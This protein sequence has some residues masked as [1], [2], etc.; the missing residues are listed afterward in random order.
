MKLLST[1]LACF[2]LLA[3]QLSARP[4]SHFKLTTG[5]MTED[6]YARWLEELHDLH[7]DGS[8]YAGL[9]HGHNF[10]TM[11]K[12]SATCPMQRYPPGNVDG[13]KYVCSPEKFPKGCVIYSIGSEGNY[14]FEAALSKFGCEIHTFDCFGD[15]GGNAPQ[16]T[17]F[18]K[19]CVGGRDY[20]DG[21]GR[22]FLTIPTM[23]SRLGH[24]RV[25]YLKMDVEGG[26]YFAV[27]QL[28]ALPKERRPIQLGLEIHPISSFWEQ[29]T[30][31]TMRATTELM[32]TI[33]DL[34]YRLVSREDNYQAK[35]CSEFVYILPDALP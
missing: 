25:D 33:D 26:E 7:A 6:E 34:G 10:F 15:Y 1:T 9:Y 23:M 2:L 4:E 5:Q 16:G 28:L 30:H 24:H 17:T 8:T 29:R 3:A 18:H 12:P 32:L 20:T 11:F 19:W 35:C 21:A 13:G 27:P 22:V 31:A 14:L